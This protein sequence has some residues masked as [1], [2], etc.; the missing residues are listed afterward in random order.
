[1]QRHQSEGVSQIDK[2]VKSEDLG[3]NLE[4]MQHRGEVQWPGASVVKRL[5]ICIYH[6]ITSI[7]H[8]SR[9]KCSVVQ[10]RDYGL[11]SSSPEPEHQM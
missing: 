3:T 1:M 11:T 9:S 10:T 2:I 7:L 8:N 6:S 4:Q 5:Y